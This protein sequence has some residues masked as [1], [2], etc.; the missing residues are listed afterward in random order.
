MS[1]F[2]TALST[3]IAIIVTYKLYEYATLKS[4]IEKVNLRILLM[5]IIHADMKRVWEQ[6]FEMYLFIFVNSK[7][8]PTDKEFLKFRIAYGQMFTEVVGITQSKV[9]EDVFGDKNA[10]NGY[11][12][13]VFETY[14]KDEFVKLIIDP[15][16]YDDNDPNVINKVVSR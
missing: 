12:N 3:I 7:T 14:F 1:Y 13:Y 10:F 15:I 8:I 9:Y 5:P 6:F 16:I 11:L 4:E 2:I